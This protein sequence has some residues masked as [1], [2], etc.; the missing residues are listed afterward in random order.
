V[1]R[2]LFHLKRASQSPQHYNSA[3]PDNTPGFIW[4]KRR[5]FRDLPI[6]DGFCQSQLMIPNL[7]Y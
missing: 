7:G 1:S 3:I 4:D 6:K 5:C 2:P